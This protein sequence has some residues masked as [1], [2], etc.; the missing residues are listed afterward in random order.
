M[1]TKSKNFC[2]GRN[3]GKK[4]LKF[5]IKKMGSWMFS[6]VPKRIFEFFVVT[7]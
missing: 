1:F 4:T 5:Y 7:F 2:L 6:H 3:L